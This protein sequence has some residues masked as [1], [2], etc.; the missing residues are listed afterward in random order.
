M[1]WKGEGYSSYFKT[2]LQFET[3]THKLKYEL[4][5][6]YITFQYEWRTHV[7][8]NYF[9]TLADQG[10]R[11]AKLLVVDFTLKPQTWNSLAATVVLF[12][13]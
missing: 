11:A 12:F 3:V 8:L 13:C 10:L 6:Y 9:I 5:D 4:T 1:R 2:F 7:T